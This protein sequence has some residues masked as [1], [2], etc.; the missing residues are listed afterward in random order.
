M[1]F[2]THSELQI[3]LLK[4]QV[5]VLCIYFFGC[6]SSVYFRWEYFLQGKPL[7]IRAASLMSFRGVPLAFQKTDS[8][9]AKM[10]VQSCSALFWT[11]PLSPPLG[12]L[13]Q[14]P[15]FSVQERA[16]GYLSSADKSLLTTQPR[17]PSQNIKASGARATQGPALSHDLGLFRVGISA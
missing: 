4:M 7:F 2:I 12:L 14:K 1:P 10:A 8:F 17:F 15:N 5:R 9:E 3:F 13:M 16:A 6:N 11:S